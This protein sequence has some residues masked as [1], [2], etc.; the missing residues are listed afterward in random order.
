MVGL[1]VV[2]LGI[3]PVVLRAFVGVGARPSPLL[4]PPGFPL[5]LR[6]PGFLIVLLV[7]ALLA[8][9]VVRVRSRPVTPDALEI[10]RQRYARG[11]IGREEY[12]ARREVLRRG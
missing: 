2:A 8:W 12:E 6:P 3:L 5:V 10:L 4:F 7:A 11:E 1:V 9:V